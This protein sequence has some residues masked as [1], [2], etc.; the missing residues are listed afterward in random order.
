MKLTDAQQIRLKGLV[1]VSLANAVENGYLD[2]MMDPPAEDVA[3]E[4]LDFDA[5]VEE[6]AEEVSPG[7]HCDLIENVAALVEEWRKLHRQ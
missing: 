1:F 3:I 7:D 2:E 4:T 5:E 6:F